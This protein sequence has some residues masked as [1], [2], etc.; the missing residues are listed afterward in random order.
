VFSHCL[1]GAGI[2]KIDYYINSYTKWQFAFAVGGGVDV[3]VGKRFAFR[4]AQIDWLPIR[5]NLELEGAGSF[6]SNWRYQ[7]GGV[8]KF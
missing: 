8:I 2:N 4:A 6:F 7:A 1:L 5:S 3:N